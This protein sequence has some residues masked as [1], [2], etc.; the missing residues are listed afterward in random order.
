MEYE[1]PDLSPEDEEVLE[2]A[3]RDMAKRKAA[4]RA[5]ADE[6]KEPDNGAVS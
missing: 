2:R 5:K 3:T 4:E 6:H 1:E